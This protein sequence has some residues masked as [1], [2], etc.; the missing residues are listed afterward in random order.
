MQRDHRGR[1]S[2]LSNPELVI[3]V[4]RAGVVIFGLMTAMAYLTWFERRV[5]G[6]LQVRPGPNRVGFAGLLQPLADAVKLL[7]KEDIVPSSA[8]KW[9]HVLAPS[10]ALFTALVAFAVL[11]LGPTVVIDGVEVP[12]VVAELPVG[13]LYMIGVS[14]LSVYGLV[15]G[16][17]SSGS[18]YSLLGGM[19]GAAQVISYELIVGLALVCVV[20]VVGSLNLGDIVQWQADHHW[21]V[22]Y[23]P[24]AFLLYLV[25][26]FAEVNRAP[27]DLPEAETELVA[28]YHTE[29]TGFRFAIFFLAEY[30]GM[31]LFAMVIALLFL[32]G[33]HT[34]TPLDT[35]LGWGRLVGFFVLFAKTFFLLSV[36]IWI[37][38]SL[39]R[40]RVDK[41]MYLC[42]K[43]LLPWSV[44]AM[45]VAALQVLLTGGK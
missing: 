36:M 22:L 26:A 14:S 1:S 45:M 32:G 44:V 4:V 19:R 11:P 30:A 34:G 21:L 39:P 16:G 17:W 13:I 28:G 25:G 3:D 8:D 12:M 5:I 24:V 38:W 35:S 10:I 23:H 7:L 42:Y 37:R 27:F 9:L 40:Y 41:V 18:K 29:Y 33:W 43:V 2:S 20:L 31:F 6:R 15:L